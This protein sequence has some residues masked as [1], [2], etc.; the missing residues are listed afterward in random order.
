MLE[1]EVAFV[2]ALCW[3]FGPKRVEYL[4]TEARRLGNVTFRP[5]VQEPAALY[6]DA[7]VLLAPSVAGEAYGRVAREALTSGIPVI[8]SAVGGL[9]ESVGGG[10]I[11]MPPEASPEDW[12]GALR[13]LLDDEAV[14]AEYVVRAEREADIQATSVAAVGERFEQLLESLVRS[15]RPAP[16]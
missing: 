13:S 4:E 1:P 5:P 7:R 12:A 10:G 2:W 15:V 16:S 9:P 14:Y 11:L 6:G 3:E 8:A